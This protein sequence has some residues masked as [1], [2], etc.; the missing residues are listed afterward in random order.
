M[1][2]QPSPVDRI[3]HNI[4]AVA[5]RRLLTWLCARL[6]ESITPDILTSIGF[7]GAVVISAGYVLS[8]WHI[9]WLWLSIAGYGIHWFGDSLDGSVARFRSIERPRFGYFIDHSTD[10]LANLIA[11]AGLGF[12]PFIRMDVALFGLIGY[13]LLSIHAFL[14]ARVVGQMRLSY[15]AGGPTELRLILIAMTLIMLFQGRIPSFLRGVSAYDFF[16]GGLGV[17]MTVIFVRQ[18]VV[19][20]RELLRQGEG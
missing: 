8:S 14:A 9:D 3:Q 16:I 13:L 5:E 4:L 12:S 6:P 11:L 18:T 20:S 17:L 2:P 10:A 15:L 19:T 1:Q 7:F